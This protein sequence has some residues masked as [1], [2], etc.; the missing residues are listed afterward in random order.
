MDKADG[1]DIHQDFITATVLVLAQDAGEHHDVV[2]RIMDAL[3]LLVVTP[4]GF[5]AERGLA[6][7]LPPCEKSDKA[8]EVLD[9]SDS[10]GVKSYIAI[11]DTS[12]IGFG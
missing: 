3:A 2:N 9:A 4:Q 7:G 11:T 6:H 5:W 10:G 12:F 8:G 1:I